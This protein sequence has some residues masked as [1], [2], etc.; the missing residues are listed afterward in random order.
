MCSG[1]PASGELEQ[2]TLA[3][4]LLYDYLVKKK[5]GAPFFEAKSMQK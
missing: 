4:P 2:Y 5:G 1:S 3:L